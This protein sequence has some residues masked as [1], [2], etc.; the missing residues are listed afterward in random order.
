MKLELEA[1]D[2]EAIAERVLDILKPLISKTA[3][4]R[5][6][7]IMGV[8]DLCTYLQVDESWVYK[9]V[10]QKTIPF[11]KAG[12]YTR[13]RKSKIDRWIEENSIKP[14]PESPLKVVKRA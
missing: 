8:H 10:S 5:Q 11:F 14:L 7:D 1:H 13:F 2:V 9:Q 4:S 6:D 12:K 3:V